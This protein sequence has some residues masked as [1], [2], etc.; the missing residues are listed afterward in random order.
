MLIAVAAV[1]FA[2]TDLVAPGAQLRQIKSGFSF[3]EGPTAD[4][5]GNVYF[6]DQPNDAIHR[7]DAQTDQISLWMQPAGRANG[8][9]FDRKG[10]LIACADEKNELWLISSRRKAT[11]LLTQNENG[12]YNGPNDAWITPQNGIY[13]TDPLYARPY[14]KRDAKMQQPG[15]FVY[16]LAPG[17]KSP[18]AVAT[19]LKQPNGIVGSPDGKTLYVADIGAWKTYRY[20]IAKNGQ[21]TDKTLFCEQGSDGM[22]LDERGN[23][24]LTGNGVTIY[25]PKGTKI[26]QI[27]VPEDWT[28]N[29][30]FGGKDGKTLFITASKSVY[31]LAM[32]VRGE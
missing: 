4:R 14:W 7:W 31:S 10:N 8:L 15:Q 3:T 13:F 25:D 20:S 23:L 19:D 9:T 27:P 16:F 24:Y 1:L 18:T 30:T 21:L 5:H 11:V 26:Q 12:L 28:A 2:P 22:A 32:T 6:T 17:T 29:V